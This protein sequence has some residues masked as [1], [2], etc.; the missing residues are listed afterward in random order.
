MYIP[1]LIGC[2]GGFLFGVL[3]T[4]FIYRQG[5]SAGQKVEKSIPVIDKKPIKD[6]KPVKDTYLEGL[7]NILHYDGKVE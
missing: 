1:I 6:K 4:F 3:A 2:F 7:T 5:I